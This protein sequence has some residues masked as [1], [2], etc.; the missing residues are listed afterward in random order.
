VSAVEKLLKKKG[1]ATVET[2]EIIKD[3]EH[4]KV[5]SRRARSLVSR[6]LAEYAVEGT[7]DPVGDLEVPTEPSPQPTPAEDQQVARTDAHADR[8]LKALTKD[9]LIEVAGH[10]SLDTD[11]TKPDLIERINTHLTPASAS[12]EDG[13]TAEDV[14]LSGSDSN[15]D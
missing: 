4:L 14:P 1:P 5:D 10:Y 8:S 3:G 11:G 15:A 13:A 9:E 7:E 2:A 12:A 6:G